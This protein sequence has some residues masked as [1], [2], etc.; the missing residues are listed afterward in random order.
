M[1]LRPH[2]RRARPQVGRVPRRRQRRRRRRR[3]EPVRSQQRLP[4]AGRSGLGQPP[5]WSTTASPRKRTGWWPPKTRLGITLLFML[6]CLVFG[7]FVGSA[8]FFTLPRRFHC[9]FSPVLTVAA[10]AIADG[11]SLAT[12]M[13]LREKDVTKNWHTDGDVSSRRS[14]ALPTDWRRQ[15]FGSIATPVRL[16]PYNVTEDDILIWSQLYVF[17]ARHDADLG[18]APPSRRRASICSNWPT[19]LIA[20]AYPSAPSARWDRIH[21]TTASNRKV[22]IEIPHRIVGL[23]TYFYAHV[24]HPC[25][26]PMPSALLPR[27]YRCSFHHPI[28][29]PIHNASPSLFLIWSR[30]ARFSVVDSLWS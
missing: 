14:A 4:R 27:W 2:R 26:R 12:S 9:V 7:F 30:N 8:F 17:C 18:S 28:H 11:T 25:Q 5:G 10:I 23:L 1:S 19:H 16:R 21:L 20:L 6:S 15:S 29:R 3:P 24:D 22:D 13:D